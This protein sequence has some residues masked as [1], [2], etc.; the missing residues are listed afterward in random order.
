MARFTV[1]TL[2]EGEVA[3]DESRLGHLR[4][5]LSGEVLTAEHRGYDEAR[6]LFNAAVDRRPALVVRCAGPADVLRVVDFARDLDLV[7]SVRGGGHNVSGNA[8]ADRGLL[9]DLSRMT[10]VRVDPQAR[11][12]RADA[13]L[14]WARF[15]RETQAVDLATTGGVVSS[16]GIAGLTLGGGFG[17]LAR[18]HGLTCDN[19]LAA[20]VVT[21]DGRLLTASDETNPDLFW[22]LRGG[23]GNFGVV[24]SFEYRLHP[25]GPVVGG[26]LLHPLE[27]ARDVLRRYLA[28]AADAPPEVTCHAGL[29]TAPDGTKVVG[30][31]LSALGPVTD[32]EAALAPLRAYGPPAADMVRPL[33]YG[34][35]QHQLD[36]S[37][38]AGLGHY[39]RSHFLAGLDDAAIDI[40]IEQCVRAPTPQCDVIVEHLGGA[41]ADVRPEATA[42]FHRGAPFDLF[43]LGVWAD[44]AQAEPCTRWVRGVTDAM[45]PF[46]AE[47]GYLNYMAETDGASERVRRAYGANYSRLADLKRQYDPT[48]FFRLN[49]NILP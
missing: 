31:V 2:A 14:T 27:R 46:L 43:I 15:D 5:R 10:G 12:A 7:V 3:L 8:V 24:T 26:L 38:P 25:V 17:Y 48:N 39:W 1:R 6:T 28:F 16:T 36:A 49:Q 30:F 20:D 33:S 45:A 40:L 11:T 13:G 32:A 44:L 34:E 4:A 41:I 37:Y 35:L 9:I 18:R 23:G 42:F 19:L 22:G 21:A 47:G 29:L